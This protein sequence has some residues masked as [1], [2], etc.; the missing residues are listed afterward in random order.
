MGLREIIGVILVGFGLLLIL[1]GVLTWLGILK[2][3]K[4]TQ[5]TENASWIDLLMALL[6]RA[7]WVVVVGLVLVILGLIVIGVELPF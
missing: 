5:A 3:R 4:I 6:E 7:P 1:V 2:P